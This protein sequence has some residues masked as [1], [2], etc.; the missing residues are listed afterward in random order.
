MIKLTLVLEDET[1]CEAIEEEAKSIGCTAEDVVL[2][3]LQF[4]KIEA[5]LDEEERR[6]ID[7]ARK[8]WE[9]NGGMEAR[10]FFD[11]LRE[12]ENASGR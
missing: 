12:E 10:A 9:E 8:E 5:E 1:L 6:E 7:E 11:S 2:R 4:W 3:A